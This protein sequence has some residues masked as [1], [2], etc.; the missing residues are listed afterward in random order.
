MP[1]REAPMLRKFMVQL[2]A[3]EVIEAVSSYLGEKLG[4]VSTPADAQCSSDVEVYITV[5][6]S[7]MKNKTVRVGKGQPLRVEWSTLEGDEP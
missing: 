5:V 1:Y 2:T 4:H 7:G 3:S 6:E